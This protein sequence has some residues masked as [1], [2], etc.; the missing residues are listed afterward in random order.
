MSK[1]VF[2]MVVIKFFIVFSFISGVAF[3]APQYA[4]VIMD[5]RSGEILRSRNADTRLHPASLTKM[6]TLYIAFEA[7]KKG[8]ITAET[9]V[10][11]SKKAASEPPSR[12]GLRTGQKIKLKYLIRAAAIMSANDA[13]TA[14]GEAI[15]GS[16]A[17]FS[18]RM[19]KTAKA[20]GMSRTTF[21]NC[22]GLTEAGH[23]STA[24][25]MTK[26]GR[27]LFYHYNDY[28]HLFSRKTHSAG[29]I[30]VRH[31]NTSFLNTYAG[32]DGIKTGYTRKA[33]FNLVASA[34][35]K[36]KRIIVTVFGGKST[37]SRNKEVIRQFGIGFKK[38]PEKVALVQPPFPIYRTLSKKKS[39]YPHKRP[40]SLTSESDL[41][42]VISQI[43]HNL[44]ETRLQ[45]NRTYLFKPS[46]RPNVTNVKPDTISSTDKKVIVRTKDNDPKIWR[47]SMGAF[48]TKDKAERHLLKATLT[49]MDNLKLATQDI[50]FNRAGWKASFINLNKNTAEMA[51]EKLMYQG[52]SCEAKGPDI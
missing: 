21:K 33:G 44:Q 25:D 46:K 41:G 2:N 22:H 30:R 24:N 15:S 9:I 39:P 35:R 28:Y 4:S 42:D 6:M 47:I 45:S 8:E 11:V 5:N 26:L 32:A 12:M 52:Y 7:I 29:N 16:E 27:N 14:I 43:K 10:T 13:A 1:H 20:L 3:S 48:T 34:K 49:E 40:P 19:N 37:A 38:A 31:T 50:A 36:N 23:L 51:C 18:R 17:A